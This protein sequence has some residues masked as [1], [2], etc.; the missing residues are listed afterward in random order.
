MA[1][2]LNGLLHKEVSFTYLKIQIVQKSL[3]P[4]TISDIFPCQLRNTN[5]SPQV[6]SAHQRPCKE[7]LGSVLVLWLL[8]SNAHRCVWDAPP[9]DTSVFQVRA[10]I[11]DDSSYFIPKIVS[12][13]KAKTMFQTYRLGILRYHFEF[14]REMQLKLTRTM[15]IFENTFLR[16]RHVSIFVTHIST[17][18]IHACIFVMSVFLFFLLMFICLQSTLKT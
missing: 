8:G 3:V 10:L 6:L 13:C 1:E 12:F 7:H 14:H 2:I 5:L 9:L 11:L 16:I 15:E 4:A 18:L 17:F